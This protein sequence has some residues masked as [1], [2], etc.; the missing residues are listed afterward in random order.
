MTRP[1]CVVNLWDLP[2]EKRPRFTPMPGVG[3]MVRQ[4]SD[5]AGLTRMGIHLRVVEPGLAGTL[6]HFHTVEE[7]W[8][9]VLSGTGAVR[10]GPHRLPVQGGSFVGFPPGPRPHHFLAEGGEPLV[11]LE[12][13][14]RRP[15]ED[16][17]CYV[18]IP[19]WWR[20]GKFLESSAPPP[21]EEGQASQ[22]LHVDDVGERIFQ[23]DVDAAARRRQ[24]NLSRASGLR[25]QAVVWSHVEPG[26]RSTAFHMHERTDEWVLILGGRA[27]VRLGGEAVE[28]G[29]HDFVAHPAGGPAH[30]M[31]ALEPLTYLMGGEID[32][33]DVVLYPEAGVRR[34][35]G[36]LEPY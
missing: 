9:Y 19:K 21:P 34:V 14:E 35:G 32:E 12:G 20:D 7:E 36:R 2:A 10:I 29:R 23:H 31:E 22:R 1:A 28:V 5:A 26:A 18:D 11:L 15:A 4:V 8:V 16:L 6:R 24:R 17:G 33:A 30:V 27:R 3:A 13:G 25:R